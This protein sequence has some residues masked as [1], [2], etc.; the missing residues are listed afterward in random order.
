[1]A[2]A[3]DARERKPDRSYRRYGGRLPR[4]AVHCIGSLRWGITHEQSAKMLTDFVTRLSDQLQVTAEGR[5]HIVD[6]RPDHVHIWLGTRTVVNGRIGKKQRKLDAVSKKADGNGID[7]GGRQIGPTCEWMRA[8]WA[9]LNREMSGDHEV[10][11]R[12]FARRGLAIRPV[13]NVPRADIE[14][15]RRRGTAT[16]RTRRAHELGERA[17]RPVPSDD[18]LAEPESNRTIIDGFTGLPSVDQRDRSPSEELECASGGGTQRAGGD[19]SSEHGHS[20]AVAQHRR[21]AFLQAVGERAHG[22]A[23]ALG[24]LPGKVET[25]AADFG[26]N[27]SQIDALAQVLARQRAETESLPTTHT[28]TDRR[29][30]A[31]KTIPGTSSVAATSK[32]LVP[33]DREHDTDRRR[34][35]STFAPE[36]EHAITLAQIFDRRR[37]LS[38]VRIAEVATI[39]GVEVEIF[40]AV[41][42]TANVRQ[43]STS[44]QTAD[45]SASLRSL[46]NKW[47]M[48]DN[49]ARR[50]R[51]RKRDP[52][53]RGNPGIRKGDVVAQS[54]QSGGAIDVD[55]SAGTASD[56]RHPSEGQQPD[57][58]CGPRVVRAITV[59]ESQGVLKPDVARPMQPDDP[60][61]EFS[62]RQA[63]FEAHKS[64]LELLAQ[65]TGK[66]W[67]TD[68]GLERAVACR[69]RAAGHDRAEVERVLDA[70]A[71]PGDPRD[72]KKRIS[73]T[74]SHAF[75]EEAAKRFL[76]IPNFVIRVRQTEAKAE[77]RLYRRLRREAMS[78][79]EQDLKALWLERRLRAEEVTERRTARLRI[80]AE[81]RRR[82]RRVGR[83]DLILRILSLTV[84]LAVIRPLVNREKREANRQLADLYN[85]AVQKSADLRSLKAEL[86]LVAKG[87]DVAPQTTAGPVLREERN[88]RQD[89]PERSGDG[90]RPAQEGP[91]GER[92]NPEPINGEDAGNQAESLDHT[93]RLRLVADVALV[94]IAKNFPWHD[95]AKPLC[96]LAEVD[97]SRLWKE[98]HNSCQRQFNHRRP[99]S[100]A[101]AD[102]NNVWRQALATARHA[103]W[104]ELGRVVTE[105]SAGR[106]GRGID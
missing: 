45:W 44:Q 42:T 92:Q 56:T 39:V 84:E 71:A 98:A 24:L 94:L 73:V 78:Q 7:V 106:G 91:S 16:W 18:V 83:H 81:V 100:V 19:S 57:T 13:S 6:G 21:E 76:S 77:A 61:T 37:R 41:L 20:P 69:L 40:E 64:D 4:V 103:N 62:L 29:K 43:R 93:A 53:Q 32:T 3:L 65:R 54:A 28:A 104:H 15:E 23:Q 55:P 1:M 33:P 67:K 72:R 75:S 35:H 14:L 63:R 51:R 50:D 86:R 2:R 58:T 25:G 31:P 52:Q 59:S 36:V 17:V 89:H 46:D 102:I 26:F 82:V 88:P 79:I 47:K 99:R 27:Q 66:P 22:L 5:V 85:A 49:E 80:L 9:Q 38:K 87:K 74:V 34:Q 95:V 96:R 30:S 48:E 11:H 10:D 68:A 90:E 60:E 101:G 12:S 8:E 97:G 70:C 105:F